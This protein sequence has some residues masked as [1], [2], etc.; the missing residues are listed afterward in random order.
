[1]NRKGDVLGGNLVSILLWIVF[2]I[3]GLGIGWYIF[4]KLV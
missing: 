1:M 2:L 3:L 4:S